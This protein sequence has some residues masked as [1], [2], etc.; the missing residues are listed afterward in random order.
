MKRPFNFVGLFG[1]L[2]QGM[3]IITAVHVIIGILGYRQFGDETLANI[4]LN[5]PDDE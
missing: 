3:A 1:V 5:L 2:N 4:T